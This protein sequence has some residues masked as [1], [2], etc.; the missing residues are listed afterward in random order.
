MPGHHVLLA[1]PAPSSLRHLSV[2][3]TG[4]IQT[5][6]MSHAKFIFLIALVI[7]F[8]V[9]FVVAYVWMR[10]PEFG[11]K[12]G[13]PIRTSSGGTVTGPLVACRANHGLPARSCP[14]TPHDA[15]R[16]VRSDENPTDPVQSVEAHCPGGS[17]NGSFIPCGGIH[18][19][20]AGKLLQT[21]KTDEIGHRLITRRSE[22][23]ILPP[24]PLKRWSARLVHRARAPDQRFRVGRAAEDRGFSGLFLG[25]Y[26]PVPYAAH[27]GWR[28]ARG[29]YAAVSRS[30][31]RSRWRCTG[32]HRACPMQ[33]PY[34]TSGRRSRVGS[35]G[36]ALL[37]VPVD[38]PVPEIV[39]GRVLRTLSTSRLLMCAAAG[40][41]GV[42]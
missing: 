7:F 11:Q 16:S 36:Q 5:Q 32:L 6:A 18:Q 8:V 26:S 35:H 9:L 2:S 23:Q 42:R 30:S 14:W 12:G 40:S 27:A 37:T 29:P 33:L 19:E 38:A 20:Y 13:H 39:N 41:P 10:R 3:L 31:L 21:S 4:Q 22:V 28:R 25:T 1:A 24:P 15:R 17:S 34:S